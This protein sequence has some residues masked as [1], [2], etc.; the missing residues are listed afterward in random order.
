[1][2]EHHVLLWKETQLDIEL[3]KLPGRRQ[4]QDRGPRVLR[5]AHR[6]APDASP[7]RATRPGS[8]CRCTSAGRGPRRARAPVHRR[9]RQPRLQLRTDQGRAEHGARRLRASSWTSSAPTTATRSSGCTVTATS[10]SS[11]ST[12]AS[13][14]TSRPA[15]GCSR[16]RPSSSRRSRWG[17]RRASSAAAASSPGTASPAPG[18]SR[19]RRCSSRRSRASTDG[20]NAG[21]AARAASPA[22]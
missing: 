4:T 14:S 11:T 12:P 8:A 18:G 19:S 6:P 3:K 21:A 7:S 2:F 16:I 5:H 1:M 10:S 17:S 20:G 9:H 22:R 15:A 13:S